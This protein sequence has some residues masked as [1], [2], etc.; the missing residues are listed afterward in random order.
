MLNLSSAERERER[1]KGDFSIWPSPLS[2]GWLGLHNTTNS[3]SYPNCLHK[4]FVQTIVSVESC[5][6]NIEILTYRVKAF[7]GFVLIKQTSCFMRI[8]KLF[9]VYWEL[10]ASPK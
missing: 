3:D 1:E 5:C 9:Y 7:T 6:N 4:V 10:P 8:E 2:W